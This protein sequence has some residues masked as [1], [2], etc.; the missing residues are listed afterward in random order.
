MRQ[1]PIIWSSRRPGVWE[2]HINMQVSA[3]SPWQP[4]TPRKAWRSA[5]PLTITETSCKEIVDYHDYIM[6]TYTPLTRIAKRKI[7]SGKSTYLLQIVVGRLVFFWGSA[8]FQEFL[9]LVFGKNKPEFHV[10]KK[11]GF[12]PALLIQHKNKNRYIWK[13]H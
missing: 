3:G 13:N 12:C 4:R 10:N 8:Y 1:K 6:I 5:S 11:V 2:E 7:H 9:L